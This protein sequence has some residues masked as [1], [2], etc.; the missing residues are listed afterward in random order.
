[1]DRVLRWKKLLLTTELNLLK[2]ARGKRRA[3]LSAHAG[4]LP[5][6]WGWGWRGYPENGLDPTQLIFNA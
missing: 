2:E 5:G 6:G 4:C 3:R 1:M